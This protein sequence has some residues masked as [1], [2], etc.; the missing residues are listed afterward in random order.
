MAK[1]I[2]AFVVPEINMG[3]M[4]REVE[5]CAAGQAQVF[6]A[7]RA[8]GDI[9]EPQHVLDVIRQAAGREPPQSISK[10]T[11]GRR[12]RPC[13]TKKCDAANGCKCWAT[14]LLTRAIG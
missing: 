14:N 5:R 13:P 4:V 12:D 10:P 6:G 7:N 11:P 2:R 9:L 1:G 8:G 3:Q